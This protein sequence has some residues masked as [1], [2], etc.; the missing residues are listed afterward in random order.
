M[1]VH[2]MIVVDDTIIASCKLQ[3]CIKV[4]NC[5]QLLHYVL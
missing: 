2:P 5:K 4:A 1:Y 3:V